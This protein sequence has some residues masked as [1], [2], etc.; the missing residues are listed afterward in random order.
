[1]AGHYISMSS[2]TARRDSH[3]LRRL[4]DQFVSEQRYSTRL[5]PTTLQAY[6]TSFTLLLSLMPALSLGQLTPESLT[7]F[8][9]RLETRKRRVGRGERLGVTAST[10]ATHRGKLGRFFSWLAA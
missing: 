9:R 8:F 4:H 7:E 3:D 6:R 2:S 10:V 1:M 5:A